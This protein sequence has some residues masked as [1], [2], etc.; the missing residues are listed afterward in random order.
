MTS[1][2]LE[3][4]AKARTDAVRAADE[5]HAALMREV[6]R[7]LE[8]TDTLADPN[9]TRLAQRAGVSRSTVYAELRR[10]AAGWR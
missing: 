1:E 9:I 8:S 6:V 3:T 5:A 2:Q 10:I 7:I 4:L